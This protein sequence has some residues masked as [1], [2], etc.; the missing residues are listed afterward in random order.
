[1]T[2]KDRRNWWRKAVDVFTLRDPANPQYVAYLPNPDG[3][4]GINTSVIEANLDL[5]NVVMS[6][7][8]WI[9]GEVSKPP[10]ILSRRNRSGDVE[11]L[12]DHP[13][14]KVL[15]RPNKDYG[16]RALLKAIEASMLLCGYAYIRKVRFNIAS[17]MQLQFVPPWVMRP[18]LNEDGYIA[19]YE[20]DQPR[21]AK[22]RVE[23]EDVI[24]FRKDLDL[25]D[26]TQGVSPLKPLFQE[27]WTDDRAAMFTAGL[28]RNM[29]RPGLIMSVPAGTD[30]LPKD[31][32]D[33]TRQYIKEEFTGQH[34]GETMFLGVPLDIRNNSFN[35]SEMSL[36]EVRNTVEER[37]CAALHISPAVVNFGTGLEQTKVGAT[38]KE[39]HRMAWENAVIPDQESIAEQLLLALLPEF[40]RTEVL[41]Q[42]ELGFDLSKIQV[43]QPDLNAEADRLRAD[44]QAGGITEREWRALRGYEERPGTDYYLRPLNIN[45][46]P[47]AG[48]SSP[49]MAMR[50]THSDDPIAEAIRQAELRAKARQPDRKTLNQDQRTLL[51]LEQRL[52]ER[53]IDEFTDQL[54]TAFLDL[55]RQVE[56][57]YLALEPREAALVGS[58]GNGL[59]V[60]QTPDD[61][62]V[63][64]RIMYGFDLAEWKQTRLGPLY[65]AHYQKVLTGTV[66]NVN[67]VLRLGFNIP[68]TLARRIL[69]E[70]GT[71][72]GLLDIDR[73]TRQGIFRAIHAAR[74]EGEGPLSIARRIRE[75][76]SAARWTNAGAHYRSRVIAITE[77]KHAQNVSTLET[78]EQAEVVKGVQAVDN[79]TGFND[80][81]CLARDGN[82]YTFEQARQELAAEHPLN[83][84]SFVP[85]VD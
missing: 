60:K 68:D 10:L 8:S 69:A 73:D 36:S 41:D 46:V 9:S 50:T 55:G 74:S 54:E 29:G 62:E 14:L 35:P 33:E 49:G 3:G 38:M 40:E 18:K 76:V 21:G 24:H 58:N 32:R 27:I 15:R 63:V 31:V 43:L 61:F 4:G 22:E 6:P 16:T 84:L 30:L 12:P 67:A 56:G 45:E 70:G 64:R 5:Q 66:D 48:G 65:Q 1:M 82:V 59:A 37:V 78:Y 2:T 34:T 19:Y 75:Q 83:T 80:A 28:L 20:R 71:Q 42:F 77:T 44:L 57:A 52:G 53:L 25:R 85:V 13:M 51:M 47:A 39:V 11:P 23:I 72:L 79:Q 26:T 17:R 81:D 7:V